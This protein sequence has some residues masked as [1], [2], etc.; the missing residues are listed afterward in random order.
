[1]K[2]KFSVRKFVQ[3]LKIKARGH[4]FKTHALLILVGKCYM[5][6]GIIWL[7]KLGKFCGIVKRFTIEFHYYII[8]GPRNLR[9]YN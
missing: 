2:I 3:A 1:V 4:T 5:V 9:I 7:K 8:E 6:L